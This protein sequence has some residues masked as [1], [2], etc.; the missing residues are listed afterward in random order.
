[1]YYDSDNSSTTASN[2]CSVCV[3]CVCV[4]GVEGGAH[5]GT[6]GRQPSRSS[7]HRQVQLQGQSASFQSRQVVRLV[8]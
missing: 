4:E 2:D 1:V 7:E 6:D 5:S 8:C 3:T